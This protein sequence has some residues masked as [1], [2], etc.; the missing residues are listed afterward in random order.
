MLGLHCC[1]RA[2]SSCHECGLL[3]SCG[4]QDSRA[5]ASVVAARGLS[6]SVACGSSLTRDWTCVPCIGRQILNHWTTRDVPISV[7]LI[8]NTQLF[9]RR[10][11]SDSP[12]ALPAKV[13]SCCM[14]TG[15]STQCPVTRFLDFYKMVFILISPVCLS[16]S[17]F[18]S[19]YLFHSIT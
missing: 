13:G 17:P 15:S 19:S 1:T 12:A 5:W 3:S 11:P 7:L 8:P 9:F 14:G 6:C 4:V 16:V 18:P 10:W 2:F